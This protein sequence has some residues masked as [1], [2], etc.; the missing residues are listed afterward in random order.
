M[1]KR[2]LLVVIILIFMTGCSKPWENKV[3][4]S[5]LKIKEE[6][7]VGKIKNLTDKAYYLTINVIL[8][9]G[10][11]KE[12]KECYEFLKPNETIN[13]N[14][15][16]E[17]FEDYDVEIDGIKF[18]EKEIPDLDNGVI[19]QDALEYH[20]KD[21]VNDHVV[22][23]ASFITIEAEKDWPFI[24]KVNYHKN[25]NQIEIF[26]KIKVNSNDVNI[27]EF[28]DSETSEFLSCMVLFESYDEEFKSTILTKV[29]SMTR[30]ND[31]S[32]IDLL[33]F[34]ESTKTSDEKCLNLD[35]KWCISNSL[36]VQDKYDYEIYEIQ[37]IE[38]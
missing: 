30:F 11:F 5:K 2:I 22:N 38:K 37:K 3:Q 33:S 6:S 21:I 8:T 23:F 1:K 26:S 16:V 25:E 18:E 32:S 19:S 29:S 4:V 24:N 7:I 17:G 36:S 28:Y 20:F 34:L 27:V 10:S 31:V 14:C 12:K 9:S 15:Y 13:M 35:N